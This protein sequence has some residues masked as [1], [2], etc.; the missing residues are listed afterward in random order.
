MGG[1][2]TKEAAPAPT[3]AIQQNSFRF[4]IMEFHGATVGSGAIVLLIILAV[5]VGVC[6]D[7]SRLRRRCKKSMMRRY[8]GTQPQMALP[9]SQQM[10][11][12]Q[13]QTVVSMPA[14]LPP[15]PQ[16]LALP[17]PQ[18]VHCASAC[19]EMVPYKPGYKYC[20]PPRT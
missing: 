3:M 6:Y 5:C 15:Q 19:T 10:V 7:Y 18:P 1:S 9:Y 13:P 16:R 14:P 8:F 4:H 2:S 17:A 11:P 20:L 12:L